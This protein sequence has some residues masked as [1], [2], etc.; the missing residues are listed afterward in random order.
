[1]TIR[2]PGAVPIRTSV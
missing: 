2:E 1:M